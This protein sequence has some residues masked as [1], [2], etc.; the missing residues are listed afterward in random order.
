MFYNKR[1]NDKYWE[2]EK[3]Y[4]AKLKK[5][6]KK[7]AKN[8]SILKS[9]NENLQNLSYLEQLNHSKWQ[10]KRIKIFKRDNF[11]CLVCKSKKH[12]NVHHRSY[13]KNRLAWQYSAK[14]LATLCRKCHESI[15]KSKINERIMEIELTLLLGKL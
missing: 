4:I 13:I 15:H 10:A 8:A 6:K 12:L 14:Y 3:K 2:K 5:R 7:S 11:T 9:D 1:E